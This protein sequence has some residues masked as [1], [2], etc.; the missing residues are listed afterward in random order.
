MTK[1]IINSSDKSVSFTL[2]QPGQ[3]NYDSY[4]NVVIEYFNN[5]DVLMQ[6]AMKKTASIR[7][8][9]LMERQSMKPDGIKW[10]VNMDSVGLVDGYSLVYE[11]EHDDWK[12][13]FKYHLVKECNINNEHL[14]LAP[15]AVKGFFNEMLVFF[16]D[17]FL[18][19]LYMTAKMDISNFL[20]FNTAMSVQH[21]KL[22]NTVKNEVVW[23]FYGGIA[24]GRMEDGCCVFHRFRK[25]NITPVSEFVEHIN[26]MLGIKPQY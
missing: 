6:L 16:T 12:N 22:Y 11:L 13:S 23:E 18:N 15:I 10:C 26:K 24:E 4:K 2:P 5:K 3:P 25:L 19:Q 1:R 7:K 17:V 14:T 20:Q 21:S 8:A 9:E